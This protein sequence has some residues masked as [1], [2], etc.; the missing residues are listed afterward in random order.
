[1]SRDDSAD[2]RVYYEGTCD[3]ARDAALQRLCRV[4]DEPVSLDDPPPRGGAV[5]WVLVGVL[6]GIA[7]G[8]WVMV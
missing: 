4:P 3:I 8:A 5:V 2:I 6:C 7:F 1:M